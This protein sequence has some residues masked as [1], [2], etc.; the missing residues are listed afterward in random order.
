MQ[1]VLNVEDLQHVSGGFSYPRGNAQTFNRIDTA[2]H[3]GL[4]SV[5]PGI[6]LGATVG[7]PFIGGLVGFAGGAGVGIYA[8]SYQS[9]QMSRRR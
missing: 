8:S 6:A 2:L 4:D 1:L 3:W 9:P 7:H 5:V